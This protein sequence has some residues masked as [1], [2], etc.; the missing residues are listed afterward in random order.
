MLITVLYNCNL[1]DIVHQFQLEIK[2]KA[3]SKDS[4]VLK[5][6]M[7]FNPEIPFLSTYWNKLNL[8]I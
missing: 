5:L 4:R 7:Y 8:E 3:T 1:Y 6:F 2:R